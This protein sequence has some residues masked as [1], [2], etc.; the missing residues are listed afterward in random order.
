MQSRYKVIISNRNL[1]KEIDLLPDAPEVHVGTET[2]C[3]IRLRKDMFF[4]S[5]VLD[6]VQQNDQWAIFCSDNLYI[7]AGDVRKLLTKTL[8]HGDVFSIKY[9]GSNNDVFT[10]EFLIDFDNGQRRYERAIDVSACSVIRIGVDNLNQIII[11]SPFVRNDSIELN[12]TNNGYALKVLKTTYGVYHNGSKAVGNCIIKNGD[13]FS[14]SDFIFYIKD[15]YIWTEIREGISVNGLNFWDYPTNSNYPKFNRNTRLKARINEDSIEILDPPKKPQKPAGNI[16]MQLLPALA[17]IALTVFVRGFMGSGSNSS[18][19]IFSV[20]SMSLGIITSIVTIITDRKKYKREIAD[21]IEKYGQYI[22]KKKEEIELKR[23][24]EVEQMK[25]KSISSEEELNNI[26]SFSSDIF[27]KVREDDDFLGIC[28][29]LGSVV[30]RRKIAFKKQEKLEI[31]DDL[32]LLP[33][34]LYDNYKMISDAPIVVDFKNDNVIGIVGSKDDNYSVLKKTVIDIVSRHYYKD[35]QLFFLINESDVEQ[36]SNWVRWLPHVVDDV[37]KCKNIVYSA[38]SKATVF[39]RLFVELSRRSTEEEKKDCKDPFYV[40]F[41]LDD[42]GLKT[43][44]LAQFIPLAHKCNT[45]FVFFEEK[46][47]DIPLWCSKIIRMTDCTN[48]IIQSSD[49]MNA[50][51]SFTFNSISDEQMTSAAMTLSPIF[52]E[53]ISLE[54]ALTRNITLYEM[55]NILSADDINLKAN[56]AE[57]QIYK[58]MAAPLGVKTKNEIVYLDLHEKAHGPHGLVAGTTGSGKSEI[59]QTYILSMAVLYH[60]Y[61]V[62]FV[63]ID[64]KGG[65]MVNQFKSLPHLIG[66]ITNIDGKEINRSLMSIKAELEKRQRIFAENNVNSISNYIKLYKSGK[67]SVPVPHLIIVVDEFAELKAEQPEFMKELISAARIGRSLGVHLILA[68]QKPAGQVNEQIWSN[69]KFKLCL[70]VQTKEDSNEVLKSPL[71]AEIKE[72]GRAYLQVG[73]NEIFELFQSAYS[74]APAS[75]EDSAS[76]KEFVISEVDLQGKRSVSYQK[77]AAKQN[78]VVSTQLDAIVEY[79]NSFCE[80]EGISRL[81]NICLPPLEDVIAYSNVGRSPSN[82][83]VIPIGIFDDP[84]HQAQELATLNISSGNTVIVGSAQFGKTNLLQLII[85]Y[86]AE[87]YSPEEVNIYVLDF[88]SM[89]LRSFET[90]QHVGGVVIASE[91]ERVKNLFRLLSKEIVIRKEKFAQLGITSFN[92]YVEAGNTDIPRIVFAIDNFIAFKE[93]YPDYEDEM[94]SLCREG[95]ALG[96]SIIATSLQT[97]G[98]SY[99]YMSNFSNK[100]CLFCNSSDEYSNLFDRCRIEPKG[101]PGRGLVQIEKQVFETQTYLAFSGER[102]ID[103]VEDIQKFIVQTNNMYPEMYAKE[104]PAIPSVLDIEYVAK[105]APAERPYKVVIGLDYNAIEFQ[106][107]DLLKTVMLGISGRENSGKTNLV[108]LILDYLQASVFDYPTKA[109]L[110][111]DYSRQLQQF[112]SYG[113]VERYTVDVAELDVIIPELEEELK[114]R[115]NDLQEYGPDYLKDQP[116]I[117]CVIENQAVFDNGTLSKQTVD[118]FKRIIANY[119]QLK[120]MFVFSNIPNIGIAYGASEMLK[121]MKE[122]NTLFIMDDLSNVKVS[123]INASLVRQFK[124]PIEIGD[125]YRILGDGSISKIRT[126]KSNERSTE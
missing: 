43:H 72:P 34:K 126:I 89:A 70:K 85:R 69:S 83:L 33:E 82:A 101:T 16:I 36:Y 112:S 10:V 37:T 48:G 23:K 12:R 118:T 51:V 15:G 110:V 119:K 54:N 6:F 55:L 92:S 104:I 26:F 7:D 29:G 97:N 45:T 87:N 67:A 63:V 32:S 71:A 31:E 11:H 111:D 121:Q 88:G 105:K 25:Q 65:G 8:N 22:T 59:L 1:Y 13:F 103:R 18:F 114:Q 78:N 39:E 102:E 117:M 44:P 60:P 38:D 64:F 95:I 122:L 53:E 40:V 68:T 116:L 56:W 81:P 99:K 75:M 58:T 125:A 41:V 86:L 46:K 123:D 91:D 66:A 79:V 5:I 42:W 96:I 76:D 50:K 124:K 77:V 49:D 94:L 106:Y 93:L 113:F 3:E 80:N 47:E 108:K 74:G 90:L 61:E 27:D 21:R 98:I 30:A 2:D 20:C 52:C 115:K 4:E 107:I 57:A 73:N 35:V 28:F 84:S 100:V 24:T 9:Q 109:Y 14:I 17:M 120:I 19:I 62:G